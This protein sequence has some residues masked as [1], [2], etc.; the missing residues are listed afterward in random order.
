MTSKKQIRLMRRAVRLLKRLGW[1]VSV[2]V[3]EEN[4]PTSQLQGFIAGEPAY[5]DY[6]LKHLD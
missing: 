5:V 6:V 2:H 4:D 1:S 3:G